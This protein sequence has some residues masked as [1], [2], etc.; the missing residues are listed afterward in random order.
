MP[1]YLDN[2]LRLGDRS[3]YLGQYFLSAMGVS[4]LVPRPEDIGFDYF[5]SLQRKHGRRLTFHSPFNVQ[6]GSVSDE[7]LTKE[8]VY[9]GLTD[10]EDPAKRVHRAW[11]IDFLRDQRLPFFVGTIDKKNHRFRL[12]STSAMWF[13]LRRVPVIG[14]IEFVPD[15][16]H[17]PIRESADGEITA[18][19]G[20][21]PRFKV[22]LGPPV[23]DITITDLGTPKFDAAATAME[24]A[25]AME[26]RNL[27]YQ[28]LG[29]WYS[30]RLLDHK[31]NEAG[32]L[33]NYSY[34]GTGGNEALI[35]GNLKPMIINLAI[36]FRDAKNFEA[37]ARICAIL[38]L[39]DINAEDRK[40]L[41][42]VGIVEN[43]AAEGAP[44]P[45]TTPPMAD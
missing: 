9:G 23:V 21:L 4:V 33:M 26:H 14:E 20:N 36:A 37:L 44:P 30:L 41:R 17:D 29:V 43:P 27:V 8:F 22:P 38:D 1:N 19:A 24:Y 40:I 15:A 45:S 7:K 18:P 3:E 13:V 2:N 6:M 42:G 16:T 25:V 12:Y 11:E 35:L 34:V 28:F 39:F 31:P 10:H 32:S 5:C